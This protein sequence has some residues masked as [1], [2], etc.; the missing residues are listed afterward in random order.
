MVAIPL[1]PMAIVGINGALGTGKIAMGGRMTTLSGALPDELLFAFTDLWKPH[2][3]GK[4][5]ILELI[6]V[7]VPEAG[8]WLPVGVVA[9]GACVA[10]RFRRARARS[11]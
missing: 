8:G 10:S 1:T 7:T 6:T 5:P 9:V 2:M 11:F 3:D 4:D